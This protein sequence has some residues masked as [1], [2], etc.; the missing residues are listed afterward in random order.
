MSSVSTSRWRRAVPIESSTGS[1][2]SSRW[3]PRD[4]S[5]KAAS[6]GSRDGLR[7][8]LDDAIG[9]A[10]ALHL[11]PAHLAPRGLLRF[12]REDHAR[13][14][15]VARVDARELVGLNEFDCKHEGLPS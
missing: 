2:S 13:P 14:A 8:E 11:E 12:V 5:R 6:S 9:V 15:R 1:G 4:V 10:V 7:G 3:P